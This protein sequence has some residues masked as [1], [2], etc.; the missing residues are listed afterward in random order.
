M[1]SVIKNGYVSDH[2]SWNGDFLFTS[3]ENPLPSHK[4]LQQSNY[5]VYS[6]QCESPPINPIARLEC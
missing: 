4:V 6:D 1:R 2:L 5:Y 3:L